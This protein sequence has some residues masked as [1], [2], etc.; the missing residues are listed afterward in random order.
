MKHILVGLDGSERQAQ[1]LDTAVRLA[2]ALG[3]QLTLLRAVSLPTELPA[4]AYTVPPEQLGSLLLADAQ[5]DLDERAR[6]VPGPLLRETQTVLG[7]PWH[8]IVDAATRLHADLIVG[9]SH[10]YGGLD[11]LLGTTAAKVVDHAK[12]SVLV[13]RAAA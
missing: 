10:G 4:R 7:T 13:A 9:G 1:V 11:R 2:E 6:R 5:R 3:G 12:C 8:A